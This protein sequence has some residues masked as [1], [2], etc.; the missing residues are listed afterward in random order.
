MLKFFI[1]MVVGG[2]I[3]LVLHCILIVGKESDEKIK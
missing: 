2:I 3:T 1:G